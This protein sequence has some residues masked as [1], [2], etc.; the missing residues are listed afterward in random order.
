LEDAIKKFLIEPSSERAKSRD[1]QAAARLTVSEVRQAVTELLG[2]Q[3]R[4]MVKPRCPIPGTRKG[5]EL[6]VAVANGHPY[7]AAQGISFEV[8]PPENVLDALAWTISD[9][10]GNNPDFPLAVVVLPPTPHVLQQDKSI[11][12]TH[13]ETIKT[14]KD[15]GAEVRAEND[16]GF[17]TSNILAQQQELMDR[18]YLFQ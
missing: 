17:W 4:D 16:I 10:K 5:H 8:A 11:E 7:L 6:D 2:K 18:V 15:L 12:K 3:H 9:I 1:R 13:R 14:Y